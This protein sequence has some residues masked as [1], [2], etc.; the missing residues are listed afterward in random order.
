MPRRRLHCRAYPLVKFTFEYQAPPYASIRIHIYGM[1][2]NM[3]M[4]WS[5]ND[6]QYER[7]NLYKGH[8]PTVS[9]KL[10]TFSIDTIYDIAV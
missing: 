9:M 1:G 3:R 4:N 7:M 8:I 2:V 5:P 6:Q 10:M